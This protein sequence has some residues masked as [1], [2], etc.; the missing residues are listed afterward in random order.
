MVKKEAK[1]AGNPGKNEPRFLKEIDTGK[2]LFG[3]VEPEFRFW[4]S[5]GTVIKNVHELIE[6]LRTM[7]PEMFSFHVNKEK[8][9]FSNWI[10]DI[11]KDTALADKIKNVRKKEEMLAVLQERKDGFE[12][13]KKQKE[14]DEKRQKIEIENA[15]KKIREESPLEK[16]LVKEKAK[17][18]NTDVI[19]NNKKSGKKENI[20]QIKP[21]EDFLSETKKQEKNEIMER[22]KEALMVI[23]SAP[24]ANGQESHT[25]RKL[26]T[27]R[28]MAG[29][30]PLSRKIRRMEQRASIKEEPVQQ[31]K[32]IWKNAG[33]EEPGQKIVQDA[34]DI[35]MPEVKEPK[36]KI[37]GPMR[38]REKEIAEKEQWLD[39]EER[40]LNEKRLK[41][42]K[43]RV[44]LIK[45]RSELEKEKF[46]AYIK[47]KSKFEEK[48]MKEMEGKSIE[49]PHFETHE[50]SEDETGRISEFIQ[51]AKALL[52]EGR[53][54][55]AK[56]KLN[57]IKIALG[58]AYLT[59]NEKRSLEYSIMELEADVK[60][61]M[62]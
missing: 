8:N 51:E 28:K 41:L 61:A 26:D 29:L 40:K 9:D 30:E 37:S 25:L 48:I 13:A 14:E 10:R 53:R 24:K 46:E 21:I 42:S 11:I 17:F 57:D 1:T 20:E 7:S 2:K 33:K 47:K 12:Y 31:D 60:L 59:L 19:I 36:E 39:A 54:E 5:N 4:L 22:P 34:K 58:A 50:I 23:K 56:K 45:K 55:E 32:K 38:K 62:L 15:I 6:A 3:D 43:M 16:A 27:I 44:E 52:S 35:S 49:V 18:V